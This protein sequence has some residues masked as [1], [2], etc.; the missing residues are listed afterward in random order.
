MGSRQS[1]DTNQA[2]NDTGRILAYVD[3]IRTYRTNNPREEVKKAV[4]D[5]REDV[6]NDESRKRVVENVPDIAPVV[7][8]ALGHLGSDEELGPELIW[9]V[10]D[11]CKEENMT[12]RVMEDK[13]RWGAVVHP[14]ISLYAFPSR[15]RVLAG[16]A[17]VCALAT[18]RE[19]CACLVNAGCPHCLNEAFEKGP[20]DHK[21]VVEAIFRA[22]STLAKGHP[23]STEKM[24]KNLVFGI[25]GIA[26]A[27]FGTH[28]G[29]L[30]EIFALEDV[31]KRH[32][33]KG[34][35]HITGNVEM[36][37]RG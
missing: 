27:R 33:I 37:S 4:Q 24:W 2:P 34:Y 29:V 7:C 12:D 18:R 15:E 5:L 9:V 30:R 16:C 36:Y 32:C 26:T 28:P 22:L 6:K 25:A 31:F 21:D 19:Y 20:S 14:A 35:Y 17:V 3:V 11:L 23:E 8:S 1:S 10:A 13:K